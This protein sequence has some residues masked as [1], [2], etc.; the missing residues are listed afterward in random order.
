MADEELVV[1]G[2]G[3]KKIIIIAVIAI[4]LLGGG[5]AAFFM[6]SG[7]ESTPAT[8]TSAP[9]PQ[10][11]DNDV[12]ASVGDAYYVSMPRPFVFNV[13]GHGRDRLVQIKVKLLVRGSQNDS[14]AKKHIPLIEDTLLTVFSSSDAEMLAT[15]KGKE[16]LRELA[17]DSVQQALK[18]IVGN[19]VVDKV[20]FT[21]F[22]M[23]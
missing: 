19:Q 23:Q 1:D 21:G 12:V 6:L 14:S 7:E 22:V 15:Q 9:Q 3:K 18:P 11:A 5:A 16:Q 17:L 4:L 13:I 10:D 2:G 20:L 8:E